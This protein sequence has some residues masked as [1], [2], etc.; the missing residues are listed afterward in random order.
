[1]R[2]CYRCLERLL[3]VNKQMRMHVFVLD[4]RLMKICFQNIVNDKSIMLLIFLP[5]DV[6]NITSEMH[7]EITHL[8]FMWEQKHTRTHKCS[9]YRI[10]CSAALVRK[11]P[12]WEVAPC[13]RCKACPVGNARSVLKQP[14]EDRPPISVAIVGLRSAANTTARFLGR[15]SFKKPAMRT[16]LAS[17][18]RKGSPSQL[19]GKLWERAVPIHSEPNWT[20]CTAKCPHCSG[21][22]RPTPF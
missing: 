22:Q 19:Q 11:K 21:L 7:F 2:L 20:V 10:A 16:C 9:Q 17:T 14:G 5:W 18:S 13:S 8:G 4:A 3:L 12:D 6:Y 15:G 1:M